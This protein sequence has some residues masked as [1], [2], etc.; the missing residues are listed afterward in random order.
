MATHT[1]SQP[2][3]Q[4]SLAARRILAVTEEELQRI[5]LDIH[6]GPVQHLFAALSQVELLQKQCQQ[7][8]SPAESEQQLARIATILE[9]ALQDMR[10]FLGAFR[11]PNFHQRSL[12]D[13]IQGLIVQH[14]NFTGCQVTFVVY[15]RPLP[16][17]L[18]VKIALYRICQEALSNAYR[19]SGALEQ[20][21]YLNR[22]GDMIR[23]EVSDKGKGFASPPLFGPEATE[24][25]EHIGLRGMRDRV[26]LI[27]GQFELDT[28][29]GRGTRIVVKVPL[30]E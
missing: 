30:D 6:D 22:D 24:R 21:V 16:A 14:E 10:T 23:M 18:P 27:N 7:E 12:P 13:I 20:Q 29:P 9:A 26:G 19:H 17:S 4:E 28:A 2:C 15:D 1:P 25:A 5:I 11:S 3:F 8:I